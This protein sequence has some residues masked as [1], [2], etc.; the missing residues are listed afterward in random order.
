[1]IPTLCGQTKLMTIPLVTFQIS[2]TEQHL[3]AIKKLQ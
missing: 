1:M 3:K 2:I